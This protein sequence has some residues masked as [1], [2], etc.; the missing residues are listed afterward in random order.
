MNIIQV[1]DLLK[2]EINRYEV[3]NLAFKRAKQLMAGSTP[4]INDIDGKR[5]NLIALEEIKK[6]KVI[7][8]REDRREDEGK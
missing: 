5:A 6:G 3:V 1:E 2:N 4:L 8:K 7:P